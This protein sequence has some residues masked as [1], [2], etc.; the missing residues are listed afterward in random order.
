MTTITVTIWHNVAVDGQ[1]HHTGMLEGYQPGDPM[2]R[3]FTYQ[4]DPAGGPE[5]IAEEAFAICNGH[6]RDAWGTDLAHRYYEREL[7][8]LS[9]GDVVVAGEVALAVAS[10]GWIPVRGGLHEVR[11]RR[12]RHP[13][14]PTAQPRLRGRDKS[15]PAPAGRN[16]AMTEKQTVTV[17]GVHVTVQAADGVLT[18]TIGRFDPAAS[19]LLRVHPRFGTASAGVYIADETG[20]TAH[21]PDHRWFFDLYP[22]PCGATESMRLCDGCFTAATGLLAECDDGCPQDLDHTGLC[23]RASP[24]ECQW[25]G[26]PGR[27][28][29]I[30][31]ADV[32]HLLP[33]VGEEHEG[34]WFLHFADGRRGPY[35]SA[36]AAWDDWHAS[37]PA[38]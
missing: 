35:P 22:G 9:K 32:G 20:D 27:L 30:S 28:R 29:E 26:T 15:R 5:E 16:G 12:V 37:P 34:L 31:R 21:R 2:V 4:A 3:V 13:P 6:P 1:G 11:N 19:G 24:A 38:A 7:R 36:Q 25:C 23:L 17:A 10:V 33:A 14:A 8:S 18:V